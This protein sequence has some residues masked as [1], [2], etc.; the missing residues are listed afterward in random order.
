MES[1]VARAYVD[2]GAVSSH[3]V[4][5][6]GAGNIHYLE[7][8]PDDGRIAILCHGAGF[9]SY[10]WQITNV[11]DT[12]A[13]NGYRALAVD[14]P[15]YGSLLSGRQPLNG[16]RKTG[17]LRSFVEA[18][19]IMKTEGARVALVTASMGAAYGLPFVLDGDG[20]FVAGYITVAGS[21]DALRREPA[22]SGAM[23]D[24]PALLIYGEE[25]YQRDREEVELFQSHF[26]N[27]EVI[28]FPDAPHPAYLRDVAAAKRF[29]GLVLEFMEGSGPEQ[30]SVSAEWASEQHFDFRPVEEDLRLLYAIGA[31]MLIVGIGQAVSVLRQRFATRVQYSRVPTTMLEPDLF[32]KEVD[33]DDLVLDT[34]SHST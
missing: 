19:G 28:V 9:S 13:V 23:L 20:K 24:T 7:A 33:L 22:R 8:G 6:E 30:L 32:G 5:V 16:D 15:G 21:T 14:F 10:T 34:I 18:L 25:D 1:E 12:L 11:L 31:V 26:P 2:T 27:S 17:F 3:Y 29:V 4:E